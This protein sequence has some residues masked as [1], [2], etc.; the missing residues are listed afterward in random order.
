MF[1]SDRSLCLLL[2]GERIETIESLGV[3]AVSAAVQAVTMLPSAVEL[4]STPSV[5]ISLLAE[6][7]E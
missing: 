5:H 6:V 4:C 2:R 7:S 3:S 1:M